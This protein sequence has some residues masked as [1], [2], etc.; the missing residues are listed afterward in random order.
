MIRNQT[1]RNIPFNFFYIVYI[2]ERK[3]NAN[4]EQ[5]NSRRLKTNPAAL[6]LAREAVFTT[7][8]S[9]R[10]TLRLI[11]LSRIVPYLQASSRIIIANRI[12]ATPQLFERWE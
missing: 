12:K 10:T 7:S 6:F 1:T 2:S 5:E 11:T 3:G 9:G 4:K 8:P